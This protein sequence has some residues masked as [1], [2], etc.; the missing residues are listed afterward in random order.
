MKRISLICLAALV[1]TLAMANI[2]PIGTAASITGTGPY[3]WS[4]NLQLSQDQ[5]AVPGLAPAANPVPHMNLAF[6]SFFTIYDFD[7]YVNGSCAGPAGWAC[8]A[9]NVGFTP[10]DVLPTDNAAIVNLTWAYVSGPP[11]TGNPSG[12]NLGDFTAR[13]VHNTITQ[14]DYAARGIKNIGSQAG[15]V[16]DNVGVT[17]GPVALAIPEPSSLALVSLA[18]TGLVLR[19]RVEPRSSV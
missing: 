16:G 5:D 1:P 7:G 9:Q 18:L 12:M 14:V 11:I 2:I 6:A 17:Q 8:T 10:D 3:T 4:Y 15:T 19:R 13:S